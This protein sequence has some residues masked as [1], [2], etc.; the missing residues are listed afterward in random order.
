MQ[1]NKIQ[2]FEVIVMN[3]FGNVG[4]NNLDIVLLIKLWVVEPHYEI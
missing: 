1:N 4:L 3:I 2:Q